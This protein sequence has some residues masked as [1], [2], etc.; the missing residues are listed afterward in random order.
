MIIDVHT[1]AFPPEVVKNKEKFLRKDPLFRLIYSKPNARLTTVEGIVHSMDRTGI[2]K[3][4]LLGFPW[5]DHGL[6]KMHNDYLL[7]E[8]RLCRDRVIPFCQARL[9][10]GSKAAAEIERCVKKGARGVGELSLEN[11]SRRDT[12]KAGLS[13]IAEVLKEYSLPVLIHV[14]AVVGRLH[15][16]KGNT[17]LDQVS[18]IIAAHPELDIILAHW[19]GGLIFFELVP[20][21]AAM[22]KHVYYDTAA[23]SY[24][25]LPQ[26]YPVSI[27]IVGSDRILFGTDAPLV[28]PERQIEDVRSMGLGPEV[29]KA[30]LGENAMK[31]LRIR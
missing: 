9:S 27:Q 4:V 21:I 24:F 18:Q 3:S 1:H 16:G 12:Q 11:N 14:S 5:L 31:L 20:E 22:S 7:E 29:E 28:R 8:G 17:D 6:V 15:S 19:G 13:T 30:I 10:Q 26:I 23:T 25:Y 2:E